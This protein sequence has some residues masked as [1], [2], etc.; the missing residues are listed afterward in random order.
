MPTDVVRSSDSAWISREVQSMVL[1]WARGERVLAEDVLARFPRLGVE[2]TVR[3]IYEEVSLRRDSGEDVATTEVVSRYPQFKAELEVLLGCDRMLRPISRVALFPSAPGELG[4]FCLLSELGRG[5]SGVTYLATEPALGSRFVVLKVVPDDEQE[6]LSLARLQHPHVI[7]LFSEQSFPDRGLRALCMPYLQ[8]AS[9]ARLLELMATIPPHARQG[10]D[11]VDALDRAHFSVGSLRLSSNHVA[12]CHSDSGASLKA[13]SVGPY[14]RY[15]DRASYVEAVCWIVACLAEGLESVHAHGLVHLDVKPSNVLIAGDGL[16]ILL[17]FHLAR[18]PVTSEEWATDRLGGTPGW[19]APEHRAAMEAVSRGDAVSEPVDER[20]DVFA[21]GLLLREALAGPIPSNSTA[22]VP[23]RDHKPVAQWRRQN[24]QVSV[25]LSD[26]V[27]K[28]LA[29]RSRDRYRSAAALAHDLRRHLN[30]LPLEGVA[31]RSVVEAWRKWRQR[32][33]AALSRWA[34]CVA[35]LL[36]VGVALYAARAFYRLRLQQLLTA[37]DDGERLR[38]SGRFAEAVHLLAQARERAGALL[39]ADH[40]RRSLDEQLA[41]A[42]R[43]QRAVALH[44]LADRVRFRYGVDLPA[45]DEAQVMADKIGMLWNE[46]GLLLEHGRWAL[47][48]S[49]EEV[50]KADLLDLGI[51]YSKLRAALGFARDA[52]RIVDEAMACCGPSAVLEREQR[53]LRGGQDKADRG[54]ARSA[55]AHYDLG[56]AALG[57]G[58]FR[59]A[60]LQLEQVLA[61]RPQEFWPNFYAGLCAY[62]T[63]RFDD[64]LSAFRVC[65]ALAPESAECYFNRGR[66]A[67]AVGRFDAAA[68]DYSRAVALDPNLTPALLNRAVLAY[69]SRRYDESI[70]DLGRAHRSATAAVTKSQVEYN[71]ALA[72]LA[73]GDLALAQASA[74]EAA[75]RGH[76]EAARLMDRLRHKR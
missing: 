24:P 9:L 20:A 5:A 28:C 18:R 58:R 25:G 3:L 60:A 40:L 75:K 11:L 54:A 65:V 70:A 32:Q 12:D 47:G 1:A 52:L 55:L 33:P 42:Q 64:A 34:A 19:M 44:E 49:T 59:E 8:G 57:A 43:G 37:V 16:P 4:P 39:G 66:A 13:G 15:L 17:D 53:V 68:L 36:A 74:R 23:T 48:S 63:G 62:R 72:Y 22:T 14:R 7:P 45:P 26:I 2:D 29:A 61:E 6:H 46:R 30:H 71:L 73:R 41:L 35:V 27:E 38:F 56:R 10:R 50:I 67:E 76:M 21:L 69:K 31:N 51:A